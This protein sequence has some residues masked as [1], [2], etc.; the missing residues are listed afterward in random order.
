MLAALRTSSAKESARIWFCRVKRWT[1]RDRLNFQLGKGAE[2]LAIKGLRFPID[3]ILVCIRWYAAYPLSYRHLEEMMEERGVFVDH[4]SINRWAIRF[5]PLLEKV[6]RKYKRLVGGSWRMD[7]TCIKVKGTWK[8]LYR[9]VDKE[10]KDL[11]PVHI[12]MLGLQDSN[13]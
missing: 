2:M 11:D 9:A 4:S 12:G 3:V 6:F 10:I 1:K 5:L 7:E 13:C 8:Y